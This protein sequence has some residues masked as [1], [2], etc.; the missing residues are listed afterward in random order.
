MSYSIAIHD[1]KGKVV[2][3]KQL[4]EAIFADGNIND[5]LIH[6]FYVLQQANARLPIAH[7]KTRAEVAGSGRKLYKQ[8]GTGNARVGSARSPIRKHGGVA[9]GPR[10]TTVFSKEMPKKMKKLALAG[11]LTIKAKND[12]MIGLVDNALTAIKTK[13]AIAM[14]QNIGLTSKKTLVV[15]PQ[16]DASLERSLRNIPKVKTIL[17]AYINPVDLLQYDKILVVDSALNVIDGL[18]K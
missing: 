1:I 15:I 13:D 14:L 12:Q 7:T 10:N 16:K 18:F 8:K 4:N 2:E 6:E 17:A 3:N 5:G 9:F 11:L